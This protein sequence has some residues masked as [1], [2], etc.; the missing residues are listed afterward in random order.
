M[1]AYK[2][3]FAMVPEWLLMADVSDRAV[4]LFAVLDRHAGKEG[5][6][7][8]GRARLAQ[9]LGCSPG[10]VDRSVRELADAGAVTTVARFRD[11]GSRTSNDYW[12]WPS[13]PP[14]ETPLSTGDEGGLFTGGEGASPPVVTH[15]REPGEREPVGT[16]VR[17][18]G[19]ATSGA[20]LVDPRTDPSY[21]FDDFW[22]AYPQRNGK[23][24]G[25]AKALDRWKKLDYDTKA[26]AFR[27]VKNYRAACDAQLQIAK[28]AERWLR[29]R[30]WDD[31]QDG[32]GTAPAMT[33]RD[34]RIVASGTSATFLEALGLDTPDPKEL[35]G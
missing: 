1:K 17:P 30:C 19:A 11:D 31:W 35:T 27:G 21:R 9:L 2:E 22:T 16:T 15:E 3:P 20:A 18:S 34:Q 25:K 23:R 33:K 10:S 4:R 12:L 24:V 29:D 6:A 5:T 8:P 14:V 13:S 7:Y 32:P 26:A 28:D